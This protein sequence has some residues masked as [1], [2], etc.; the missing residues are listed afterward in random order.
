[1]RS[2]GGGA[3]YAGNRRTGPR[4]WFAGGGN[5]QANE[6][7]AKKKNT[8]SRVRGQPSKHHACVHIKHADW[9]SRGVHVPYT[10]TCIDCSGKKQNKTCAGYFLVSPLVV[11][12]CIAVQPANARR[13]CST[14][15][16][17]FTE[18]IAHMAGYTSSNNNSNSSSNNSISSSISNNNSSRSINS[19]S[20]NNTN[21]RSS[22]RRGGT[23]AV[24]FS[25]AHSPVLP[26]LQDVRVVV[27]PLRDGPLRG[28]TH[29]HAQLSG[30]GLEGGLRS[31]PQLAA[32]VSRLFYVSVHT[33]MVAATATVA[34][35]TR[36]YHLFDFFC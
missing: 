17:G 3:A 30:E 26:Q 36:A 18:H 35:T 20:S 8:T 10:L 13:G 32:Q 33:A 24:L 12:K 31:T 28:R 7:D 15:S 16:N 14:R 25:S 27:R 1:M 23:Q 19:S 2:Q 9:V 34:A 22:S 4:M 6:Q 11:G 29:A 21:S 5:Q